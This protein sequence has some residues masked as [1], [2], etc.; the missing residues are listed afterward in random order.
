[1]NYALI[2]LGIAALG[3]VALACFRLLVTWLSSD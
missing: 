2:A 3:A 1:M